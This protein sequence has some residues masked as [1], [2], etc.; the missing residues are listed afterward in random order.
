[1]L[2]FA[3]RTVSLYNA[4]HKQ[5]TVGDIYI[6]QYWIQI[7]MSKIR[8]QSTGLHF[9]LQKIILQ[10]FQLHTLVNFHCVCVLVCRDRGISVRL[11]YRSRVRGNE[12]HS[13]G[14]QHFDCGLSGLRLRVCL[15]RIRPSRKNLIRPPI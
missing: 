15:N 12:G 7:C 10:I 9:F 1:M 14:N 8:I 13:R 11:R 6:L 4:Y 5:V 3:L 2:L